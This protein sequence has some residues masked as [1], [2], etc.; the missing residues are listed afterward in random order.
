MEDYIRGALHDLEARVRFLKNRVRPTNGR[1]NATLVKTCREMLDDAAVKL[2]ALRSDEEWQTPAAAGPRF[3]AFREL[4]RE[5]DQLEY[6]GVQVLVRW[7][8]EQDGRSNA[9]LERIATEI[10]YPLLAPV[11]ACQ[12][13]NYYCLYPDLGLLLVPPAEGAFLLHLPDLYH[14]LAHP[15]LT[16]FNDS[17]LEPFQQTLVRLWGTAQQHIYTELEREQR[18]R[19][20]PQS[21]RLYLEAWRRSWRS[22]LT[23]LMCDVFAAHTLGPAFGWA[24]LHLSAKRGID[25]FH[26]PLGA[27]STHPADNARLLC[28]LDV[29]R[30]NN[31]IDDAERIETKWNAL[32]TLGGY[33]ETPEYTRCYPRELLSVI[34]ALSSDAVSSA[35]CVAAAPG[36]LGPVGQVL[37]GAWM[38]FWRDAD[39]YGL[40][41]Q[42]AIASL[43][44]L[45]HVQ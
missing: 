31:W 9:L 10:H 23:E 17:K 15:L 1:S 30:R 12:S 22:W 33:A 18:R 20:G 34:A 40:W 36:L 44:L 4:V 29:L 19:V 11:L 42:G 26:V 39:S 41:Q 3:R 25:P 28:V 24:H 21:I 37:N 38:E 45:G 6:I 2:Q 32:T 16:E 43:R 7:D 35:G 27:Q 8:E 5:L 14:E 13:R